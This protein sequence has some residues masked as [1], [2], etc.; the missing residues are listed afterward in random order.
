VSPDST[1]RSRKVAAVSLSVFAGISRGLLRPFR[2]SSCGT[3]RLEQMSRSAFASSTHT[4]VRPAS[5]SYDAMD[6][7]GKRAVGYGSKWALF[8]HIERRTI[9]SLRAN[10]TLARLEPTRSLRA[11]YHSF[12]AQSGP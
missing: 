1:P 7:S 9:A 12:S 10:A 5:R 3:G 6:S 2:L 11:A 4:G 8:F